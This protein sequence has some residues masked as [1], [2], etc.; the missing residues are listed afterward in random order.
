MKQWPGIRDDDQRARGN[1]RGRI[2]RSLIHGSVRSQRDGGIRA[3]RRGACAVLAVHALELSQSPADMLNEIW[4]VLAPQGR[5]DL[6]GVQELW[7]RP[8]LVQVL[9]FTLW[10]AAV[11]TGLTLLL[12]LPAA[13]IY[14]R[15]DF[16]ANLYHVA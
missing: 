12:G 15:Y 11:S 3:V 16:P 2:G 9:W 14:A 1:I 7:T 4:R 6:S 13:Y 10:Q 8:Y 5:L